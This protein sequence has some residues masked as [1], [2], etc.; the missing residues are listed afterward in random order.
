MSVGT[1]DTASLTFLV[2]V[3]IDM[4]GCCRIL[5]SHSHDNDASFIALQNSNALYFVAGLAPG[6]SGPCV[7]RSATNPQLMS[8]LWHQHLGDPGPAQLSVLAKHSTGLSSQ[9]T[10]D[11]HPI[12][13]CQTCND[14]KIRHAPMGPVS[15]TAPLLPGTHFHLDFGFIYASSADFSVS[16]SNR[17][18]T[19][20]DGNNSYLLIVCTKA[21]WSSFQVA[22]DL[23]R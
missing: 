21:F 15:D 9:L 12:H 1:M 10:V 5:L 6:S 13:S 4:P 11:L 7:S 20:Y 3:A 18:V 16:A 14:D 8:E 22:P 19:S 23:R 17:V 2:S